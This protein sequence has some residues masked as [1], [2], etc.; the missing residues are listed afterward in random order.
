MGR[1]PTLWRGLRSAFTAGSPYVDTDSL[2]LPVAITA[3]HRALLVTR[4][5]YSH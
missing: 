2:A 1:L 3:A 5:P 4:V